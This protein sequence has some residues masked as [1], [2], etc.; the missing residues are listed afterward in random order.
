MGEVQGRVRAPRACLLYCWTTVSIAELGALLL[1]L[2]AEATMSLRSAVAMVC[3]RRVERR[4]AAVA[5]V[6]T[7]A[8]VATRASG[9][10][11]ALYEYALQNRR[12]LAFFLF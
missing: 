7:T 4:G 3:G 9:G 11:G 6:M 10:A 2:R 12:V 1:E 8:S 5:K